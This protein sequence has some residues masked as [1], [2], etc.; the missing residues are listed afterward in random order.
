M[1]WR[2]EVLAPENLVMAWAFCYNAVAV[3]LAAF[4]LINPL[5][6]AVAMA[7]SSLL[8]V[9]NSARSLVLDGGTTPAARPGSRPPARE[10]TE[11]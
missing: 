6:A 1:L 3:P 11:A 5:F 4:G 9:A 7:A 2:R 8:V 10:V